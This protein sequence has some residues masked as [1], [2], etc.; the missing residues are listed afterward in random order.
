MTIQD[1]LFYLGGTLVTVGAISKA[2]GS[3]MGSRNLKASP[4]KTIDSLYELPKLPYAYS[5]LSPMMSIQTLQLNHDRHQASYIRGMNTAFST[6]SKIR[7]ANY[8]PESRKAM[9]SSIIRKNTF[10]IS[11]SIMNE[12]FWKNLRGRGTSPSDQLLKQIES[13]FGS[14]DMFFQEFYDVGETIEGSGWAVLVWSPE[15]SKLV[16]LPIQNHEENWIPNARVLLVIDVWEHAYYMD[17]KN[18]RSRYLKAVFDEINWD[19]V[20][21]RF[22]EATKLLPTV[23]FEQ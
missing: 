3:K 9:R 16:M 22:D 13:D 7:Q 8:P 12:L 23:Q 14:L 10:N 6:L 17:Y 15:L 5:A 19:T 18:E 4:V 21:K 2:I 20:S 11:G 1:K